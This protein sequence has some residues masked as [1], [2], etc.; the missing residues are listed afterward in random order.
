LDETTLTIEEASMVKLYSL[1]ISSPLRKHALCFKIV[2]L[3]SPEELEELVHLVSP[4]IKKCWM[5]AGSSS[6]GPGARPTPQSMGLFGARQNF[7]WSHDALKT[8]YHFIRCSQLE[9]I[10]QEGRAPIQVLLYGSYRDQERVNYTAQHY[11]GVTV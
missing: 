10:G 1:S 2:L 3:S 8:L 6:S 4:V 11:H 5:S 9:Y 7:I